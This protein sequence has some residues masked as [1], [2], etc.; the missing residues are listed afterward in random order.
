VDWTQ[1][2]HGNKTNKC[3]LMYK[4]YLI[5]QCIVMGYLQ[6]RQFCWKRVSANN[7]RYISFLFHVTV[8]ICEHLVTFSSVN[9]CSQIFSF[10][11]NWTHCLAFFMT[12]LA[13]DE[14]ISKFCCC[15]FLSYEGFCHGNLLTYVSHCRIKIWVNRML[16]KLDLCLAM[17]HQ[18]R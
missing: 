15:K 1:F 2:R 7:E 14:W 17:H 8:T 5:A 16:I 3:T 10:V 4:I 9:I 13:I 11:T 12:F 18:C 6:F